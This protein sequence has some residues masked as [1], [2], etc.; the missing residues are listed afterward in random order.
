MEHLWAPWRNAYVTASDESGK[1]DKDKLF[2][3]IGQSGDDEANFVFLR[4]RSVFA[5]LNRFPY[6]AG[7]TLVVPYREVSDLRDLGNDEQKN[8]WDT[9]NQVSGLLERALH[10]DGFNIGI[11]VGAAAGAGIPSHL[12][13]H[14]VP[15]WQ[16]DSNFMTAQTDTRVHPADLKEIYRK[17]KPAD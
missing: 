10:P 1:E 4:S 12:H 3:T 7:H 14:V 16:N 11:N 2:L 13:V 17:L 15:R 8:L 5:V 9:V 6:N